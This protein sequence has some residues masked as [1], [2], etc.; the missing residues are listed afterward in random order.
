MKSVE[1]ADAL[2]EW[3]K[4]YFNEPFRCFQEAAD[5]VYQYLKE[6]VDLIL[7]TG[8][9]VRY[10]DSFCDK[11]QRID[12]GECW[13]VIALDSQLFRFEGEYIAWG[14]GYSM[15]AWE[16]ATLQEVES[17]EVSRIEYFVKS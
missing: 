14:S 8:E 4:N 12:S 1:L 13:M 6:H 15:I 7:P 17:R 9:T 3:A 5:Y 10:V 2:T 11:S 16:D